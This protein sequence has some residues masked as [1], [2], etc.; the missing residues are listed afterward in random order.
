MNGACVLSLHRVVDRVERPHDIGW[1][2]LDG[3]LEVLARTGRST[4]TTLEPELLEPASVILT[5]D[6]ATADHLRVGEHLAGMGIRAVFFVPTGKLGRATYIDAAGV[7][8]LRAIGHVVGSHA[9]THTP[10]NRLS[11]GELV[12][13]LSASKRT[14]EELT[15]SAVDYFAPPG[16]IHASGMEHS[17]LACGYRAARSMSWG[18]HNPAA[19]RWAVPV[20]P[21]TERTIG[22]GWV[23][24]A[25]KKNRTPRAMRAVATV[26]AVLP[27]SARSRLTRL[28]HRR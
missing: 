11:S 28:V 1:S 17:L 3:L 14:L 2:V 23:A 8:H 4:G 19:S 10:L 5:F 26:K 7:R 16:G 13:E 21:V 25:L 22:A 12:E 9:V 27:T 15:G 6:D 20:V 24:M 18:I